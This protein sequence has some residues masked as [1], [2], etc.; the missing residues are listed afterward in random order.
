M[1]KSIIMLIKKGN[2]IM[3]AVLTVVGRDT[4][5]I[6]AKVS[7]ECAKYNI[8]ISEVTQSVLSDMFCMIM[9]G[10]IDNMTADFGDFSDH[11]K[12]IGDEMG[13][14]IHA[15]H[16]NIFNSMHSI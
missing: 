10:E 12:Q 3:K 1:L 7:A 2:I 15:M 8:N 9:I 11:M 14:V 5:G 6:L 4:V 16:E 13:M